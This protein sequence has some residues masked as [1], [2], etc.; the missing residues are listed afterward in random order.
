MDGVLLAARVLLALACV[1]GLV[2]YLARRFGRA[3]VSDTSREAQLHLVTRQALGR[4][5]GVAVVAVGN[6]RLLVGYG[7]Q[8]VTMLTEIAP[9]ADLPPVASLPTPRPSVEDAVSGAPRT[10]GA[11]PS[12][13]DRRELGDAEVISLRPDPLAGSLLSPRTWRD[14]VRAL[15]DRTVRR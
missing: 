14:T 6:R 2:W 11:R 3:R 13:V 5:A 8:H 12:V 1:V 4:H 7:E 9:V 15:Q 10:P